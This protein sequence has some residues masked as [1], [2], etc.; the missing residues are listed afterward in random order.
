MKGSEML[1]TLGLSDHESKIY[2]ALLRISPATIAQIGKETG[3]HRPTIYQCLPHLVEMGIVTKGSIGK[4]AVFHAESPE[5]L[6]LMF[7]QLAI[8]FTSSIAELDELHRNKKNKPVAKFYEGK[9]GITNIFSDIV[10]SLK[11]GEV[12]YRYSSGNGKVDLEKFLPKDYREVR[13][14]KQ[15]QRFVITNDETKSVKKNRLDR[16]LKVVPKEKGEFDFNVTQIIYGNKVAFL[17]YNTETAFVI[18][19]KIIAEYQKYLYKLLYA[20]L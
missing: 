1:K 5:K 18:E 2:L 6:R 12:F 19:N 13:D 4:R 8:D 9:D 16:A 20:K 15:L 7:D 11:K 10:H 3:M 14:Q 17:D